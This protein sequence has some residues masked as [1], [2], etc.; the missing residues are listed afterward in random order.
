MRF[1]AT[2]EVPGGASVQ[3]VAQEAVDA[4]ASAYTEDAGIDVEERLRTELRARGLAPTEDGALG[5]LAR[6]IRS[7]HHVSLRE[8]DGPG[9]D[10]EHW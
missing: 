1:E 3:D 2:G 4:A 7:G 9:P 6:R 5:A 8:P 10:P